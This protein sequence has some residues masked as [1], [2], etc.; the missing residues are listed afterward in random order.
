VAGTVFY[1]DPADPDVTPPTIQQTDGV[2]SP[3][4]PTE[5]EVVTSDLNGVDRVVVL[6]TEAEN[7]G[8]WQ[9]T[10]L[11]AVGDDVW[12]GTSPGTAAGP[13]VYIVQAMDKS[14]N[15]AISSNKA[16]YYLALPADLDP[17][18]VT[19]TKSP[20]VSFA[21]Q[22]V[23]VTIAATD[24]PDGSG[25]DSITYRR[26]GI[27]STE[28]NLDHDE[29]FA[30]DVPVT[31]SGTSTIEF[32]ATDLRGNTSA[33]QSVTVRIDRE[34]A[35]LVTSVAPA[36]EWIAEPPALVSVAKTELPTSGRA[37]D[38]DIT[39]GVAGPEPVL[40]GT[41]YA[42]VPVAVDAEG[43]S[44][45][46]FRSVDGAGNEA[47]ASVTVKIDTVDPSVLVTVPAASGTY[48]V[49]Q[50][51]VA[52]FQ[53]SDA[54]PGSGVPDELCVGTVGN[55]ATIDTSSP[56]S[57][58]FTVT[59]TDRAGNTRQQSVTYNVVSA[60]VAPV[61]TVDWGQ[62]ARDVGFFNDVATVVGNFTDS[63]SGPWKL[64]VNWGNGKTSTVNLS[65]TGAFTLNSPAYGKTGTFTVTVT[66]CDAANLCS[67]PQTVTVRTRISTGSLRPNVIC[68]TDTRTPLPPPAPGRYIAS[69]GWRNSQSYWIYAP[70]GVYNAFLLAP[71]DRGQPTLFHPGTNTSSEVV[72]ANFALLGT[73]WFL[74]GTSA[75]ASILSPRCPT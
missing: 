8:A 70:I 35:E 55:G 34:A 24:G 54:A 38:G 46:T 48:T 62:G 15:V 72:T 9:T 7:P 13:V 67:P 44:T 10:E 69:F 6:S 2:S 47:T 26:N 27:A 25:V 41:A 20:D 11:I 56:G 59:A 21:N 73:G 74:G 42:G 63:G 57:K 1:A 36:G 4:L 37:P 66:A 19:A 28:V 29:P 31:A 68:V 50:S 18:A 45:V 75:I 52:S 49:G 61:L 39:Y 17:P 5:F 71:L 40:A 43:E 23:T 32:W 53:C 64:A 51:V 22:D 65:T 16:L 33:H 3:G 30:I 14:G 12:R 58:T 60:N